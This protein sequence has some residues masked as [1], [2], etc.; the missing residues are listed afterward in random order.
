M[1][2]L[3]LSAAWPEILIALGMV[4]SARDTFLPPRGRSL[5]AFNTLLLA[6]FIL[7]GLTEPA[8]LFSARP[9][10]C[11]NFIAYSHTWELSVHLHSSA[12][13]GLKKLP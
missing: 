8:L 1:G 4:L 3:A 5:D 12:A 2:K 13:V 9:C 7:R 11:Y 6:L 10:F